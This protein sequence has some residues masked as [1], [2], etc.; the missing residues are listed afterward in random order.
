MS[1]T[2]MLLCKSF[3]RLRNLRKKYETE[4]TQTF[5]SAKQNDIR[6][7]E[8]DLTAMFGVLDL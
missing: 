1:S 8:V 4:N 2:V 5:R 7:F 3:G 6:S